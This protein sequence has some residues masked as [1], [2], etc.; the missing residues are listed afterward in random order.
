MPMTTARTISHVYFSH[1]DAECMWSQTNIS[2]DTLCTC[3]ITCHLV[4]NSHKGCFFHQA[5]R[6]YRLP[7]AVDNS[8]DTPM[9]PNFFN[10]LELLK[11]SVYA[12]TPILP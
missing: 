1:L 3:R 2:I 6:T 7:D 5:I 8:P 11:A 10:C 9:T 4:L 12:D